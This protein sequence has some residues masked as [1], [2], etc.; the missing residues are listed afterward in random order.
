MLLK[1]LCAWHPENEYIMQ[2]YANHFNTQGKCLVISE[3]LD[4]WSNCLPLLLQL[5]PRPLWRAWSKNIKE[6]CIRWVC[7]L[8]GH[9]GSLVVSLLAVWD[10][11]QSLPE[12]CVAPVTAICCVLSW[13]SRTIPTSTISSSSALSSSSSQPPTPA[14][15]TS[16]NHWTKTQF[17]MCRNRQKI[18]THCHCHLYMSFECADMS[19]ARRSSLCGQ[20]RYGSNKIPSRVVA[21]T[22]DG[23]TSG[24]LLKPVLLLLRWPQMQNAHFTIFT[25]YLIKS[26]DSQ[27]LCSTMLHYVPLCSNLLM[28]CLTAAALKVLLLPFEQH[29][30]L[31]T[32][33]WNYDKL[34][35]HM[36]NRLQKQKWF[37]L[38]QHDD[39][40]VFASER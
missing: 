17:G 36:F 5:A 1:M 18:L 22:W 9:S 28:H 31:V 40:W 38:I 14:G 20:V 3:S 2:I 10:V 21:S 24:R 16:F 23:G 37:R 7:F 25:S 30:S 29:S 27:H 33:N 34:N 6:S 39:S 35:I 13:L 8:S 32:Q 12:K 19:V 15:C 26:N 4:R 11:A